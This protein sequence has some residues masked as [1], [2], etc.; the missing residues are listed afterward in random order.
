M[1]VIDTFRTVQSLAYSPCGGYLYSAGWEHVSRWDVFS[2][3][4]VVV[5]ASRGSG[6]HQSVVLSPA[7]GLL[8]WIEMASRLLRTVRTDTGEPFDPIQLTHQPTLGSVACYG[9]LHDEAP[10][11]HSDRLV[12]DPTGR[13]IAF[14]QSRELRLATV[15]ATL[16]RPDGR[17]SRRLDKLPIAFVRQVTGNLG[18]R[19][20]FASDHLLWWHENGGIRIEDLTSSTTTQIDRLDHLPVAVTPD[21]RTGIAT[22]GRQV[23]LI[24]LPSG[25]VRERYDWE[26][27]TVET[28]VVAPDGMTVAVAGWSGGVAIFDLM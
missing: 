1:R 11:I 5:F 24:D 12:T 4:E 21:G 7:G 14:V 17:H 15:P 16:P 18:Q 25:L 19:F 28:V 20:G 26:V 13:T 2:G 3:E 8:G 9:M 23:L 22:G 6:Y 10:V 27:G